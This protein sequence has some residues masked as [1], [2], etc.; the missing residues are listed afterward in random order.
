MYRLILDLPTL[1]VAACMTEGIQALPFN[2]FVTCNLELSSNDAD[3]LELSL[4]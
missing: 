4:A 3:R 2:H 1:D